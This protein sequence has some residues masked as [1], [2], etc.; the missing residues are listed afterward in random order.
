MCLGQA[1][2]LAS[3]LQGPVQLRQGVWSGQC[4]KAWTWRRPGVLCGL[5]E[6]GVGGA[7]LA[8]GQQRRGQ[9]AIEGLSAHA[10]LHL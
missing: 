10:A 5:A 2:V 8:P 7:P 1:Q 6:L 3:I 4:A 9:A